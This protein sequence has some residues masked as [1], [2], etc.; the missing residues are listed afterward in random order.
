MFIVFEGVDGT[1][2]ST[3]MKNVAKEF[4][5]SLATFEPNSSKI[6][7]ILFEDGVNK[8]SE[9]LLFLADRAQ[10]LEEV[11]LPAL[12]DDKMVFCD[13]F[14]FSNLIYQE[15]YK[16]FINLVHKHFFNDIMPDLLIVLTK[17]EVE[18]EGEFRKQNEL[19]KYNQEYKKLNSPDT[20]VINTSGGE[21]EKYERRIKEWIEIKS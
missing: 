1:G 20:L 19:L 17:D 13:R 8:F 7:E 16:D 12:E 14:V 5:N 11:I 6:R 3:L 18:D 2:K 10:H 9:T 15:E 4:D 21:W